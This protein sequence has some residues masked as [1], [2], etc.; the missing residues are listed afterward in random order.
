MPKDE[1]DLGQ[2]ADAV[3]EVKKAFEQFKETNDERLKEV[4]GKG[5]ADPLLE[6]KL[7]KIETDLAEKQE[8]IDRL[9]AASKRKTVFVDGEKADEEEL[10]V[11]AQRWADMCAKR[12]DARSQDYTPEQMA[13]YK[14]ALVNYLRKD[15]R[16]L[17]ADEQKALSVGS[18]PDGGY[19][20]DPDTSGRIVRKQFET[21]P[22]RAHAT[23]Q[24]ISTDALEGLF[25]LDEATSG[26]VSETGSR[27]VTDT[28][29]MKA[30]RI[31]VH[32]QYAMPQATQKLL[33][34]AY[35]DVEMWLAD[36]VADKMSRTENAAFVEGN[37]VGKPRGFLDYADG[38]TLPGTIERFETGVD[39]GFA[40]DPD[41]AN[42][43]LDMIQGLK[44]NYRRN[45]AWFMNRTTVGG[46]RK[47]Q[48]SDGRHLWQPSIAAGQPAT[49]LGYPVVEF[50]DMP[51]YTTTDALAIAF[52]DMAEAYTIVDR[53]GVRTLRDPF[54]NKPYIQFYTVKRVG[55][56]VINFEALKLLE[57]TA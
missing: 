48:D 44:S 23:I 34:D 55:G 17:S 33:D 28:P 45:A 42:I 1:L 53:A 54:S 8:V 52:G 51:D 57:F 41:G 7:T 31:P 40:A 14:R 12:R 38:S 49:L 50:E 39:G 43:L 20:V 37:G 10:E 4:E 26:W 27:S 32:E 47:M 9:Y 24:V 29:E 11:K 5:A 13:E 35:I 19:I 56:D 3:I 46:V 18:D 15:D 16:V 30:W 25:D 36:K 2:V 22:M 21:S 6:E